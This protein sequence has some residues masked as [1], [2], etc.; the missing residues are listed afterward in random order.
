VA[1]RVA[2][3]EDGRDRRDLLGGAELPPGLTRAGASSHLGSRSRNSSD[4]SCT[5]TA[6]ASANGSFCTGESLDAA[7]G[8][9]M[10][11]A[12][13]AHVA[14][15]A[16]AAATAATTPTT[17]TASSG[18]GARQSEAAVADADGRVGGT[19]SG[20]EGSGSGG[21]G[22]GGVEGVAILSIFA[23]EVCDNE[24]SERSQ[25]P[26]RFAGPDAHKLTFELFGPVC[27]IGRLRVRSRADRR[28]PA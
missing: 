23:L 18:H 17:A 8:A 13:L 6:D 22:G 1:A 10:A 21:G 16:A 5:S 11:D 7:A 14:T 9:A 4:A 20:A 28:R 12:T 26:L 25:A 19:S 2:A 3:R 27:A 15:A 24:S